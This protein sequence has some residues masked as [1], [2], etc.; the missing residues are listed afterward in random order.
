M[1]L[2]VICLLLFLFGFIATAQSGIYD[3]IQFTHYLD[4]I[5]IVTTYRSD[6][7]ESSWKITDNK[8]LYITLEV[9]TQPSDVTVIIEHMHADV[10]VHAYKPDVDGILQDTMDDKI[11]EG[12]QPGF[13]VSPLYPYEEIFAVEGYSKWLID[14]WISLVNDFG[15]GSIDEERLNENNL[16]R[17]GAVGSEIVIVYDVLIKKGNEPYFH[18]RVIADDFYIFFNGDFEPSDEGEENKYYLDSWSVSLSFWIA[19]PGLV[20]FGIGIYLWFFAGYERTRRRRLIGQVLVILGIIVMI[21]GIASGLR[22]ERTLVDI[23]EG[24]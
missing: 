24:R 14:G 22:F 18:K 21:I 17:N 2:K 9:T 19:P 6:Y 16:K 8:E 13:Y 1:K 12:T 15:S 3:G 20:F 23:T 7:G 4:G 11:H 5:N 10:S